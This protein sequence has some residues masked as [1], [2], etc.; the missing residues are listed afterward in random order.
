MTR[1]NKA[2]RSRAGS[3]GLKAAMTAS[4]LLSLV[5]CSGL[6]PK[7]G[8]LRNRVSN[9]MSTPYSVA[10]DYPKESNNLDDEFV[11]KAMIANFYYIS[12]HDNLREPYM[13]R[14]FEKIHIYLYVPHGIKFMSTYSVDMNEF[15]SMDNCINYKRRN[16][17]KR[18]DYKL[19]YT[20]DLKAL[21]PKDFD[22][23]I[24]FFITFL[25]AGT[26]G[27]YRDPIPEPFSLMDTPTFYFDKSGNHLK[28]TPWSSEYAEA[29]R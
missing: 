23:Y 15:Y 1:I 10:L 16:I 20:F 7:R 22:G 5:G 19:V 11:V 28:L 9:E 27:T 26:D 2:S 18:K 6:Q 12:R 8:F 13:F 25:K 3:I 4:A 29:F 14:H 21:F 24:Q 17:A